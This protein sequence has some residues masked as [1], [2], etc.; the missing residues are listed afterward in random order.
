MCDIQEVAVM[1]W[2]SYVYNTEY[3]NQR[4]IVKQLAPNIKDWLNL[5]LIKGFNYNHSAGDLK[6][7]DHLS[8]R[9]DIRD[10]ASEGKIEYTLK[11]VGI[12]PEKQE[13]E[14]ATA[15]EKYGYELGSKSALLLLDSIESGR[16]HEDLLKD[17]NFWINTIHGLI[18]SSGMSEL[19]RADA[20]RL[21]IDYCRKLRKVE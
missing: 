15:T 14:S 10:S 21:L 17:P 16:I 13:Y 6:Q 3:Q 9:L 8:I 4:R 18:N 12:V 11:S 1:V 5:G 2:H 20:Q 19:D 7:P